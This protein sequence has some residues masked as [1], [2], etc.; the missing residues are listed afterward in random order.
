MATMPGLAGG[1]TEDAA[2][3]QQDGMAD[4]LAVR[5][6]ICV[7]KAVVTLNLTATHPPILHHTPS[8]AGP[9]RVPLLVACGRIAG[10]VLQA[11]TRAAHVHVQGGAAP[12]DS[13]YATATTK[14]TA[15]AKREHMRA[16][17]ASSDKVRYFAGP[18]Q[19][20]VSGSD[21]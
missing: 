5:M 14:C 13:Q 11:L 2:L 3:D 8:H 21:L 18:G 10:R 15:I 9:T 6:Q 4:K 19:V 17:G 12:S 16:G 20:L 1:Y 7:R